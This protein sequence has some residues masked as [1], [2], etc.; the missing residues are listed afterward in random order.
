M[1]NCIASQ[2]LLSILCSFVI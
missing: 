1:T 2:S